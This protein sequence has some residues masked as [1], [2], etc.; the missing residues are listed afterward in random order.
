MEERDDGNIKH[1]WKTAS[2][3]HTFL[4]QENIMMYMYYQVCEAPS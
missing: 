4:M 3:K 2:N 1:K